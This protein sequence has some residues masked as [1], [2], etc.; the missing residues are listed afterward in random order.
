MPPFLRSCLAGG[1]SLGKPAGL[2][3]RKPGLTLGLPFGVAAS[4]VRGDTACSLK[5]LPRANGG[6]LWSSLH[7]QHKTRLFSRG[8]GLGLRA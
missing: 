1:C 6:G 3:K 8:A 4:E 5:K 7:L 2:S